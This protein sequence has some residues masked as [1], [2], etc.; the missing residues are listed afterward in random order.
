MLRQLS[1][2]VVEDHDFQREMLVAILQRL[3]AKEIHSAAD[4][5]RALDVLVKTR[6]DLIISDIDM[7]GMEGW[8]S[9]GCVP[10]AA[11]WGP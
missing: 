2:L 7:P 6:V 10:T 9:C 11:I 3:N 4:G 5:R 8:S 1:V